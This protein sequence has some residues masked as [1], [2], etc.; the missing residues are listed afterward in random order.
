M[1]VGRVTQIMGP[2]IDVRFNHDEL[3]KINNAL[4][5]DVPKKDGT[6]E[7]LTLEVALELGAVSY[8]H[9]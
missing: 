8:T 7:S 5:L 9:L 3:P 6:T 2:V 4:V 1:G